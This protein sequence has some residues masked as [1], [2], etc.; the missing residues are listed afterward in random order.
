MKVE[1]IE[2]ISWS[3][4]REIEG[5][6]CAIIEP[7]SDSDLIKKFLLSAIFL[8]F[9]NYSIKNLLTISFFFSKNCCRDIVEHGEEST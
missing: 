7:L 3:K 1:L 8:I 9:A 4:E 6:I 2:L 5:H